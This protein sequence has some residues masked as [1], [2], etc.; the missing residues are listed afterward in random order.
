MSPAG[1]SIDRRSWIVDADG[2]N[3]VYILESEGVPRNPSG[4]TGLKGKG[5]LPRWGP[6]HYVLFIISRYQ[7]S[8][9]SLLQGRGLEIALMKIFRT[10]QFVLPGVAKTTVDAEENNMDSGWITVTR[11]RSVVKKAGGAFGA[12]TPA[13]QTNAEE[14]IYACLSRL[15][16]GGKRPPLPGEET[17]VV[18][19]PR[20]GLC[21]SK[22]GPS[23]VAE[24]IWGGRQ[25]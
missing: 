22:V 9:A 23:V 13:S 1:I 11:R 10:D 12:K 17:K 24:A 2:T 19:R 18:V 5:A 14:P 8:R 3:I 25:G 20:G 4:R 16:R 7:R 15:R 6:N 21:I